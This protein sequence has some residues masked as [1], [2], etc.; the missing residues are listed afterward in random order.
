MI[1]F[2]SKA[3][4]IGFMAGAAVIVSLQQLKGLLG[5]VHFTSQMQIIPVLS[6]VFKHK[7]E[8]KYLHLT[9]IFSYTYCFFPEKIALQRGLV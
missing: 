2:L 3:T 7:D 5:M 9:Y 8:V 4:L 1:D 6:S